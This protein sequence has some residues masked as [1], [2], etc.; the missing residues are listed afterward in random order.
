MRWQYWR[1]PSLSDTTYTHQM[2]A[3]CFHNLGSAYIDA[4]SWINSIDRITVLVILSWQ[5]KCC[6]CSQIDPSVWKTLHLISFTHADILLHSHLPFVYCIV[7]CVGGPSFII[8]HY[9]TC[10]GL[11]LMPDWSH[12]L[13]QISWVLVSADWWTRE[14]LSDVI[15]MSIRSNFSFCIHSLSRNFAFPY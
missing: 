1:Q 2:P 8:A 10:P 14:N 5:V 15:Y 11:E 13:N 12:E 4:T 9:H 3:N 6:L 7:S